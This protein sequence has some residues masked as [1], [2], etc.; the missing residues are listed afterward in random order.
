MNIDPHA[1]IAGQPA[2]KIR[3]LFRKA[4]SSS[5]GAEF[6]AEELSI[7]LKAARSVIQELHQLGYIERDPRFGDGPWSKTTLQGNALALASAMRPLRRSSADRALA[8]FLDRVQQLNADPYYLYKVRKVLLFGSMLTEAAQVGDVD[9]AVELV[10]RIDDP[11][12]RARAED[13]RIGVA[14]RGRRHFAN[15]FAQISWPQHEVMLFLKAR[16]RI[17]SLHE[18]DDPI[19]MMAPTR[20]IFEDL[21]PNHEEG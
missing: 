19:L 21:S 16:S 15:A 3:S 18:P 12:K 2:F 7:T 9:L 10:H 6:V 4:D 14:I 11:T 13:E 1:I 8:E 17:L 5:W 20:I